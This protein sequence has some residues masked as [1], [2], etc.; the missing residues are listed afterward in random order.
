M[1]I[2]VF[3]S[4]SSTQVYVCLVL[5]NLSSWSQF[6]H[7]RQASVGHPASSGLTTTTS[8]GNEPVPFF[9]RK[10]YSLTQQPSSF[11]IVEPLGGE[12]WRSGSSG[13]EKKSC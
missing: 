3:G 10:C 4:F 6:C 5:E 12:C 2:L 8:M 9:V 1:G 13:Q 7:G 11:C